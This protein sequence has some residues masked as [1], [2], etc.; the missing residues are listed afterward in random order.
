MNDFK[1]NLSVFTKENIETIKKLTVCQ[2][3]N[4]NWLEYR[5]CLITAS[6]AHKVV[7]KITKVG[8][9]GSGTV[10]MWYF[11]QNLLN[12]IFLL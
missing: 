5:K 10:N 12:Q 6:K 4:E 3:E 7:A 11:N 9:G 2:S 8:K 1:E